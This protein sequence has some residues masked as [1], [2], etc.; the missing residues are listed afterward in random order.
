M[1]TFVKQIENNQHDLQSQIAIENLHKSFSKGS[2]I[3]PVLKNINLNIEKGEFISL[4]GPSGCGKSTLLKLMGGLIEKT[5]GG[6]KLTQEVKDPIQK[7]GFMFQ[8]AVLLPWR[9]VEQNLLL[10]IELAK[11]DIER[12]S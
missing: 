2:N 7:V 8:K 3:V 11:G 1:T 6:Y 5:V 10:P 4:L 12:R 9:T